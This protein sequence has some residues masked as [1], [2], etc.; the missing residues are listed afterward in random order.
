MLIVES[1]LLKVDVV[2][3]KKSLKDENLAYKKKQ[4]AHGHAIH[5]IRRFSRPQPRLVGAQNWIS[6]NSIYNIAR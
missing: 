3:W 1:W 4:R 5:S 6:C 2:G